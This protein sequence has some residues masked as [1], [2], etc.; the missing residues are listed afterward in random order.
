MSGISTDDF[1]QVFSADAD[2]TFEVIKERFKHYGY[3]YTR[4]E[5]AEILDELVEKGKLNAID[6]NGETVWR[7][8]KSAKS[9]KKEAAL[10]TRM[11]QAF[12]VI[13]EAGSVG[14]IVTAIRRKYPSEP[15]CCRSVWSNY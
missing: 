7:P 2:L 8:I 12:L 6:V 4:E 13:K 5:L 9:V 1:S 10:D 3:N 14:I 15:A 11:E